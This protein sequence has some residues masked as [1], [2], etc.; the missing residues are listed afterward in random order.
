[1]DGGPVVSG[2]LTG[3]ATCRV[4]TSR[5]CGGWCGGEVGTIQLGPR[6]SVVVTTRR[7]PRIIDGHRSSTISCDRRKLKSSLANVESQLKTA[8]HAMRF[9]KRNQPELKVFF[10]VALSGRLF[11]GLSQTGHTLRIHG[12]R[13]DLHRPRW[14]PSMKETHAH[15]TRQH[16]PGYSRSLLPSGNARF[17]RRSCEVR[18]LP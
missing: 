4:E 15:D 16:P 17:R 18:A 14:P 11:T 12:S 5:G 6:T 8:R 13:W 10:E 2:R 9:S 1:M 7:R 3:N